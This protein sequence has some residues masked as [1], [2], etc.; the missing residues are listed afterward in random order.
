M[1]WSEDGRM[2]CA[3]EEWETGTEEAGTPPFQTQSRQTMVVEQL[4]IS[5][6]EN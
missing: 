2:V 5:L 4:N 6:M 3:G 1:S